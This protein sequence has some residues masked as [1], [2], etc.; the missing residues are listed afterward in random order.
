MNQKLLALRYALSSRARTA[1][2]HAEFVLRRREWAVERR[3]DGLPF[4]VKE[5]RLPLFRQLSG[6]DPILFTNKRTNLK[7]ALDR[8]NG[9]IVAPG[10]TFSFWYL[11][12]PP[13][14]AKGYL[15]GLSL[16]RGGPSKS[17]GGGLCQ[18][19]NALYWMALHA[20]FEIR[21][22]HHHSVDLFP[23][24]ARLVPFGTGATLVHNFKDLRLRNISKEAYQFVFDLTETE[25]VGRLLTAQASDRTY[26]IVE[27][28]HR[29][30]E[31][32]DGLYRHN[33]IVRE[34]W[35]NDVKESETV[36]YR[37]DSKCRYTRND[38][39]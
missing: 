23:D 30:V 34:S 11:V 15:E 8:M 25:L 14:S 2:R 28:E 32:P 18:L 38:L 12:G 9:I 10:Q 22:R 19:A 35:K 33:A 6:V 31:R 5:H 3:S 21:E 13:T 1:F 26:R 16:F 4:L 20:D 39:C 37:N 29:F 36:L 17:I 24:D 7:L 27:R